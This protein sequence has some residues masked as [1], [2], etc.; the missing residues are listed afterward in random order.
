MQILAA[1]Q[2]EDPDTLVSTTDIRGERKTIRKKHLNGRSPIETLL[3]DL[4]TPH[5]VFAVKKD[6]EN[7]VQCLFFAHRKQIELL[8]ANPDILLMDCTYRTNKY[9]LPLLHILG[10]TNL[11]SFFSAAF[12]FLSQ[13]TELDYHWAISNSLLKTGTPQPCVF[14]SDQEEA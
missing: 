5:W 9:K 8:L 3:E 13:E 2:K 12:C 7:H 6:T 14:I 11:Q 1:I 4:S 10:C